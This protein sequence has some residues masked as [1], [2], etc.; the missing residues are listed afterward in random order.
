MHGQDDIEI[1]EELGAPFEGQEHGRIL[2]LEDV[3]RDHHQVLTRKWPSGWK[4][5]ESERIRKWFR[6]LEYMY[7]YIDI[8]IYIHI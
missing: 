4:K 8:Y 7:L 3:E 1:P 6:V 5:K 2:E